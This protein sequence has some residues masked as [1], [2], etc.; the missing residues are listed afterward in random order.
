VIIEVAIHT[1]KPWR[2]PATTR[3]EKS[4]PHL[5]KPLAHPTPDHTQAGQHHLHRMRH[6]M[7]GPTPLKAIDARRWHA[8][9]PFMHANCKV[10]FLSLG[11]EWVVVGM[12]EHAIVV[13]IGP[14][15]TAAHA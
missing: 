7:L 10:E 8:T 6:D 3:F 1:V 12:A 4:K 2:N 15:E 5:G 14:Q 11:P 13:G 9:G